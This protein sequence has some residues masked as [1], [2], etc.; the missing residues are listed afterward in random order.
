MYRSPLVIGCDSYIGHALFD[1]FERKTTNV[2]G[3]T[4][5]TDTRHLFF[6]LEEE[7]SFE[8][9][10]DV[11]QVAYLCAAITN[12]NT[13]ERDPTRTRYINVERTK[14]LI[15][16]L[17]KQGVYVVFLSSDLA[18]DPDS[19]YGSQKHA[20][21]RHLEGKVSTI[22]RLG[23][24]LNGK[25]E[26]FTY[27][28]RELEK[29]HSITPYDDCFFSPISLGQTLPILGDETLLEQYPK[30]LISATKP[31]SYFQAIGFIA[32]QRDLDCSLIVP[33]ASGRKKPETL[34]PDSNL[35]EYRF[36]A[37]DTLTELFGGN[38]KG[39]EYS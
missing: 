18:S 39:Y 12:V 4:R 34:V 25:A 15:D 33:L 9:S 6:N 36:S 38:R 24:V 28:I 29:G 17:L 5:R 21:E 37:W 14:I 20:I 23:K 16:S 32:E 35:Q 10:S 19:E 8:N 11:L 22:V 30:I 3:T 2:V 13:C 27:W 7:F 1:Y 31:I 26:L